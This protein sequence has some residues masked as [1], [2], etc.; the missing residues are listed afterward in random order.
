MVDREWRDAVFRSLLRA[1]EEDERLSGAVLIGSGAVG[2]TDQDS[3]IDL[4][5]V[6]SRAEDLARTHE[7]WGRKVPGLFPVLYHSRTPF[8]VRNHLHAFVLEGFL[9]LD[10]SFVSLAEL[11]VRWDRGRM[12]FDRTGEVRRRTEGREMPPARPEDE[13]WLLNAACHRVLEC[14]KS[15]RRGELWRANMTLNELRDFTFQITGL[16]VLRSARQRHV[17]SLPADFL[18][19]MSRTV[20]PV[21]RTEMAEA[22]RVLT[23]EMLR[24]ARE[25]YSRAG[26]RFPERFAEALLEHLD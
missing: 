22:L 10:L 24:P 6:V 4:V 17:D 7:D 16:A 18:R 25:L 21:E 12:V 20:A 8:T 11:E 9:G 14:R 15:L 5:A 19:L 3:D 2:F 1:L 23:P 13:L 26:A